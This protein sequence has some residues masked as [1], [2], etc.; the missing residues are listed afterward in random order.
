MLAW[1]RLRNRIV[2]RFWRLLSMPVRVFPRGRW[3]KRLF[4]VS[5]SWLESQCNESQASATT[6]AEV[7]RLIL[8]FTVSRG[9]KSQGQW[10]STYRVPIINIPQK[11][12]Y[13]E[14]LN[15]KRLVQSVV[16][17]EF[18]CSTDLTWNRFCSFWGSEFCFWQILAFRNCKKPPK[19]N[20]RASEIWK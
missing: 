11:S 9:W 2:Y 13:G 5:S 6:T 18:F 1:L 7:K 16:I 4:E 15:S 12:R 14:V 10:W 19:Y 17:S 3:T 20:F 8:N